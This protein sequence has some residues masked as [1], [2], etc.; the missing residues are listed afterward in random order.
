M[1]SVLRP[2]VIVKG[3]VI[4]AGIAVGREAKTGL[5]WGEEFTVSH[6]IALSIIGAVILLAVRL[7]GIDGNSAEPGIPA[8]PEGKSRIVI[9]QHRTTIQRQQ[10]VQTILIGPLDKISLPIGPLNM[11]AS[12]SKIVFRDA[13]LQHIGNGRKGNQIAGDRPVCFSDAHVKIGPAAGHL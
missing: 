10:I 5:G 2:H 13:C 3:A 11:A 4:A 8:R 6:L 1:G 12:G 7:G 9:R